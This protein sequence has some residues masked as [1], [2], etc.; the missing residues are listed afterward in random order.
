MAA[1]AS[2]FSAP[3]GFHSRSAL[4]GWRRGDS[5]RWGT[6]LAGCPKSAYR[7]HKSHLFLG[8]NVDGQVGQVKVFQLHIADV[9]SV[10]YFHGVGVSLAVRPRFGA[11]AGF[12][13]DGLGQDVLLFKEHG[14]VA[15]YLPQSEHA[16]MQR[17]EDGGQHI[18]VMLD[19]VQIETVFVITGVQAFVVVKFVLQ[20]CFQRA[21]G[22]KRRADSSLQCGNLEEVP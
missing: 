17:G 19:L 20:V 11:V 21:I 7:Q 16:V 4:S 14:K 15:L 22:I 9:V 10:G 8:E 6:G 2:S 5:C 3:G 13:F 18:G 12:R 1:K